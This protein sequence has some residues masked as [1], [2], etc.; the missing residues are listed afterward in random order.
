MSFLGTMFAAATAGDLDPSSSS[1]TTE[2]NYDV[3]P[4]AL[5][6]PLYVPATASVTRGT[7]SRSTTRLFP[8]S[9]LSKVAGIDKSSITL[10]P[11]E[12][13]AGLRL[14]RSL[15][16]AAFVVRKHSTGRDFTVSIGKTRH[17]TC[18]SCSGPSTPSSSSSHPC[19][20]V[21]FVLLKVLLVPRASPL[22]FK[23][24]WTGKE[25]DGVLEAK[26]RE[27][28]SLRSQCLVK[29]YRNRTFQPRIKGEDCTMH[30]EEYDEVYGYGGEASEEE[31]R[32]MGGAYM[33]TEV[34]RKGGTFTVRQMEDLAIAKGASVR[35]SWGSVSLS[36]TVESK[37][38]PPEYSTLPCSTL[39]YSTLPMEK[40]SNGVY[41]PASSSRLS[42]Y[43]LP[44]LSQPSLGAGERAGEVPSSPQTRSPLCTPS[45]SPRSPS[46]AS[47]A[48]TVDGELTVTYP[49]FVAGGRKVVAPGVVFPPGM[50]IRHPAMLHGKKFRGSIK[51]FLYVWEGTKDRSTKDMLSAKIRGLW[52]MNSTFRQWAARVHVRNE[53]R[54]AVLKKARIRVTVVRQ[55]GTVTDLCLSPLATGD[56]VI[57]AAIKKRRSARKSVNRRSREMSLVFQNAVI[58]ERRTLLDSGVGN[59]TTVR[60]VHPLAVNVRSGGYVGAEG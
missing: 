27:E 16:P 34:G 42:P 19:E 46:V 40:Q 47:T 3:P 44:G 39:P 24:S 37:A 25:T 59:R 12:P 26:W 18:P 45:G 17:C 49:F 2:T 9:Q 48:S 58:D 10:P 31:N 54:A 52:V 7:G 5:L 38:G 4:G 22:L 33:V 1:S 55:D 50:K 29:P 11:A 43:F 8:L 15:G 6:T 28:N 56:E 35:A 36:G 14:V 51:E 41:L 32:A 60:I 13:A 53:E 20:A 21:L 23:A 57:A 30:D